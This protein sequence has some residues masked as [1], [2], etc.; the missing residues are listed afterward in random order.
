MKTNAM[1][2]AVP[3]V[4]ALLWSGC[5]IEQTVAVQN[6]DVTGP[7]SYPRIHIT[8]DSV[9]TARA[10][11]HL[12]SNT[13]TALNGSFTNET[14][15]TTA[16]TAGTPSSG[17][18]HWALPR[19]EGGFDFDLLLS[20]SVSLTLGA[21]TSANLWGFNAGLG[22]HREDADA[23]VRL[24]LGFQ[25]QSLSYDID[26]VL[27]TKTTSPFGESE[28]TQNFHKRA[29]A[30]HGDFYGSLTVN[31]KNQL[32]SLNFFLQLG[33]THQTIFD[34]NTQ[35]LVF[36]FW[37]WSNKASLSSSYFVLTPGIYFDLSKS[38]RI[39]AGAK[40][41][42]DAG[43]DSSDPSFLVAPVLLFDFGL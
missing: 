18:I 27:T 11:V 13:K 26:Y 17:K 21:N 30:S 9:K 29:S 42:L 19:F 14:T 12:S 22:L 1:L 38:L 20:Q 7:Q 6:I 34:I 10:V 35:V 31:T 16:S 23:A 15:S 36:P 39:V 8:N 32:G 41:S 33:Y 4:T 25:W 43:F 28:E 5:A 24:D 3:A 40:C 2:Y 37:G